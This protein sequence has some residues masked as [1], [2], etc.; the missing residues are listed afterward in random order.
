MGSKYIFVETES[1]AEVAFPGILGGMESLV[2]KM[3]STVVEDDPA[4]STL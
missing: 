2:E 3:E 4:V 1:S